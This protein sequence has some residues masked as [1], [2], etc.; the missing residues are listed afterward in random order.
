MKKSVFKNIKY[1]I[2]YLFFKLILKIFLAL[3]ID[4]ASALGGWLLGKIGPLT[5]ADKYLKRNLDLILPALSEERKKAICTQVWD[6]FGRYAGEF[7]HIDKLSEQEVNERIEIEGLEYLTELVKR[8]QPFIL[9]SGH[10]ANW[11]LALR[12]PLKVINNLS[13]IYRKINNPFIDKEVRALRKSDGVR[14]IAKGPEGGRELV[15]AIKSKNPLIMLADQKMNEGIS[16][17]F[18]EM[19]AMTPSALAMLARQYDYPIVP[20]KIIRTT[21]A[22]F[23]VTIYPPF[24]AVKTEDKEAD[25][26]N[27]MLKVNS[28]YSDWIKEDPGQ[29]FWLHQRWGKFKEGLK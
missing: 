3:G 6:N 9:F 15:A 23:K 4:K 19:P 2:E 27:I 11:D 18:M 10:F 7:I 5:T 22:Y 1:L 24:S 16:V 21:G 25:I 17:P 20:A 26:Y 13:V 8:K 29:W 14:L 28:Y 12:I